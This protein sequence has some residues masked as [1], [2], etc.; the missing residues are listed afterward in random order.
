VDGGINPETAISAR[1]VGVDVL[2]AGTAIFGQK[3]RAMAIRKLRG[4]S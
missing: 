4:A 1:Q 2:V 3:D